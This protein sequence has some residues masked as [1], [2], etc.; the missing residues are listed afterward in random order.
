MIEEGKKN[1]I[2]MSIKNRMYQEGLIMESITFPDWIDEVL[3][4]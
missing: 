3:K 2:I 4:W 1:Q